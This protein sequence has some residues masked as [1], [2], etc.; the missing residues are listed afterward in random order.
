MS[1]LII[2]DLDGT[3]FKTESVDVK[4]FND[5]LVQVGRPSKTRKE[6]LSHV[7]KPFDKLC[8]DLLGPSDLELKEK[9]VEHVSTNEAREIDENGELYTGIIEMLE[10]LKKQQFTLCICTNGNREY[11]ELISSKFEFYDIFNDILY[12][13]KD[14][15]KAQAVLELKNKYQTETFI[16]VG[17][18]LHDF[19]AARQHGGVVIGVSY[20]YGGDEVN[21]ADYIAHSPSGVLKTIQEIF[22]TNSDKMH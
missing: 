19:D 11:V 1:R 4:A 3:L 5:A 14:R 13:K 7:G 10:N 22:E 6:I 15:T 20:G 16:M 17:D 12:S 18:R 8:E 9:F 21:E 2:F